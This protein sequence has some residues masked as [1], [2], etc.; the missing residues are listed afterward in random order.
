MYK[1]RKNRR[2]IAL[3]MVFVMMFAFMA[4]TASA[5]TTEVQPRG[6]CPNC[7]HGYMENDKDQ[8]ISHEEYYWSDS[9][10]NIGARHMHYRDTFEKATICRNCGFRNVLSTYTRIYCP[11]NGYIS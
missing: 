11:Y 8:R 3:A 6:T 7:T 10:P 9:C 5:A 2:I 4:V 1:I